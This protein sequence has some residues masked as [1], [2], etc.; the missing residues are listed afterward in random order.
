MRKFK[1]YDCQHTFKVP[2]GEGG[3]GVNMVCPKCG[4]NNVHRDEDGAFGNIENWGWRSGRYARRGRGQR[5][6]IE[7]TP[8][9]S[10]PN[11]VNEP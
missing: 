11:T 5:S 6:E 4:S 1:C 3:R 2:H 10:Q 9:T 8:E 7:N